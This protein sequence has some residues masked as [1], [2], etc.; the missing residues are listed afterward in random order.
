MPPIPADDRPVR[1]MRCPA[2]PGG[3]LNG[4][5]RHGRPLTDV[6]TTRGVADPHAPG[7]RHALPEGDR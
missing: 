1:A 7:G 3:P 2:T 4:P 6:L 5:G